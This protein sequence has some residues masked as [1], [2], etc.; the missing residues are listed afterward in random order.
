MGYP[1]GLMQVSDERK[2]LVVKPAQGG[3]GGAGHSYK[4]HVL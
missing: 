2:L 4:L 1:I 3:E